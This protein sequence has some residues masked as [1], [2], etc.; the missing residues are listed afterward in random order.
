MC[1][2][3]YFED[4]PPSRIMSP[5]LPGKCLDYVVKHHALMF[6]DCHDGCASCVIIPFAP[7]TR[8]R[9]QT[10]NTWAPAHKMRRRPRTPARHWPTPSRPLCCA[11]RNNQK[12]SFKDL[13]PGGP[14]DHTM[15]PHKEKEAS[16]IMS[17]DCTPR[18]PAPPIAA[19]RIVYPDLC[20]ALQVS[21]ERQ[22]HGHLDWP[23][24]ARPGHDVGLPRRRQPEVLDARAVKDGAATRE[25]RHSG[26]RAP[27]TR[28]QIR[29]GVIRSASRGQERRS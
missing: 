1:R 18:P 11:R 6:Y 21:P 7:P 8:P 3:S 25:P 16:R 14:T 26:A 29:S 28:G 15:I 5:A 10:P 17:A 22:V 13:P 23:P 9:K 24:R 27:S 4:T 2:G 20:H 19:A 12:W